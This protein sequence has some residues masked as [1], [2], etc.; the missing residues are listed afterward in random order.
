MALLLAGISSLLYGVADFTGGLATRRER[1]FAV[2]TY[3]QLIG[4]AGALVAL[5]LLPAATLDRSDIIFG[6]AA[7]LA[8]GLALVVFYQG[9]ATGRVVVVA[10]V[11]ALMSAIV[12]VIAGLALG[13]RPTLLESIGVAAALPAIWLVSSGRREDHGRPTK[14]WMGLVSGIGFGLFFVLIAQTPQESGLWPLVPAR[15]LSISLVAAIGLASGSMRIARP[16]VGLI[17][18]AGVLDMAANVAFLIASRSELL[19]LV[20]V[21]TSLYPAATLILARTVLNERLRGRQP[22]GLAL[23]A[24]GVVLIASG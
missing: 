18:V 21:I 7:G 17:A 10:P 3:S 16:T 2:V 11:A 1:V 8:G 19:A 14:A 15:I 9:L 13:E 6:A 23:A 24:L 12:P 4:L 20:A 5:G 22:L